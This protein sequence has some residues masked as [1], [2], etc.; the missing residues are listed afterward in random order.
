MSKNREHVTWQSEDG[1]WSIGFYDNYSSP[2]YGEDDDFDEEWDVDYTGD[3]HW[4]SAGHNSPE[5]AANA[6]RGAN[7]G[8]GSV[9]AYKANERS[10][11]RD[12]DDKAA[13]L[14]EASKDP[15]LASR[16]HLRATY[17]GPPKKREPVFIAHDLYTARL[18]AESFNIQGYSNS[19]DDRIPY[20]R[21]QLKAIDPAKLSPAEKAE[22]QAEKDIYIGNLKRLVADEK[23][24][25]TGNRAWMT[26][27]QRRSE[28]ERFDKRRALE[29]LIGRLETSA[30]WTAPVPAPKTKETTDSKV[31]AKDSQSTAKGSGKS[32]HINPTTGRPNQ[33]TATKR[34]CPYGGSADHYP[35][36]DAARAGYEKKMGSGLKKLKK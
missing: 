9:V 33:C 12:F 35:S 2:G 19:P 27:E 1:S 14:Y 25:P 15:K 29:E 18:E 17:N 5:S 34:A 3:F 21:D 4:V 26:P 11:I 28:L 8:G 6:W 31:Q 24:R 36:K 7:P 32:Y 10:S 30:P 13:Q 20:W 22:L 23:A 16:L